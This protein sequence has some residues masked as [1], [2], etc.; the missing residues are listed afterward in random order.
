MARRTAR[1]H[2]QILSLAQTRLRTHPRLAGLAAD[3]AS[4]RHDAYAAAD[5]LLNQG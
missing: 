4:G 5:L 3:V 1:A 2:A